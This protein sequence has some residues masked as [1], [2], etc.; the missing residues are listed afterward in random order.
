MAA[1]HTVHH[2]VDR[3]NV[4]LEHLVADARLTEAEADTVRAEFVAV[5]TTTGRPPWTA[6]L[7][8]VGGYV[9][10]AFVLAAALVLAIPRWD[11][12]SHSGQIA[13]LATAALVSVGAALAVALSAPG[14]WSVHARAGLGVRRRLVSVLLTVGIAAAVGAVAVFT[15]PDTAERAAATTA[16]V[17]AITAYVFCRIPLLHLAVLGSLAIASQAWLVSLIPTILGGWTPEGPEVV[18]GPEVAIGITLVIIAAGWAAL[19]IMGIL[20]ERHLGLVS[21]GVL[22]FIGAEVLATTSYTSGL[23]ALIN[24]AGYV[25]LGLLAAAGLIGYVRTRYVGVLAVGVIALATVV[26]QAVIDYTN[27]ALGA[28]G[29]LLLVGLSIVGASLVGVRLRRNSQPGPPAPAVR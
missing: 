11:D 8:E 27:G 19:A 16:A 20:D 24:A 4:A 28:A 26:P 2:D 7:P 6:V 9:G 10:A 21:A 5:T 12:F 25:L 3:L 18:T 15:G 17:L 13:I 23:D 22:F 14:G 1:D 29:A